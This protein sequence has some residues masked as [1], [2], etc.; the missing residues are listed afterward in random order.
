MARSIGSWIADPLGLARRST[1]EEVMNDA[2]LG[3]EDYARCL[4]NLAAVNR[5]TFTHRPILAWLDRATR[6]WPRGT[7]VSVL[8]V[9][10]GQGDLLRAIRRWANRRGLA[11]T[12]AGI[13]LNPRGAAMAAAATPPGTPISYQTGDVFQHD[14]QPLPDFIVSSHFAHHLTDA[15]LVRFLA[16]LDAHAARGWFI[17]DLH[18]HWMPY[19]GFRVLAYLAGWH[20][21]I[22][23]D[24]TLSVARS[25]RRDDWQRAF[26]E[27]G[28]TAEIA[29]SFPF[30]YCVGRRR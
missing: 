17:A 30:R 26:S 23:E 24:G 1:E 8:D 10:C 29:W 16:W 18:R 22:R 3:A 25:F 9:A 27:A 28:V 21:I 7:A 2:T 13:D 12:L 6:D 15:E 20:R 14:P 4:R 5:I 19:L 11:A